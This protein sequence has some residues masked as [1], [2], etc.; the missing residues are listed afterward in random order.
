[1]KAALGIASMAFALIAIYFVVSAGL[2]STTVQT[3]AGPVA[4]LELMHAQS[5]N[6][7]EGIGA[8]VISAILAIGAAIV[9]ALQ[10]D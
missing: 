3:D 9:A 2:I 1:M 7:A 5:L 8:A 10:R 4:N 6:M